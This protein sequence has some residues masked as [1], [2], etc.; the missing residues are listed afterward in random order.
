[1]DHDPVTART[2][3]KGPEELSRKLRLLPLVAMVCGF[4]LSLSASG[5]EYQTGVS[6]TMLKKSSVTGNGRK[7]VYPVTDNA[8]VTAMVVELA[9]GAE[10]GWH[11]HPIP[12]YGY[13]L[14]GTIDVELEGGQVIVY[15]SGDAIIEAVDTLHNGRN[16]GSERVRLVVFYTGVAGKPNV[17]RPVPSSPGSRLPPR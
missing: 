7:I 5:D 3:E 16:R 13:V 11:S 6:A 10:T 15:R 2:K 1:M 8:E 14:T 12:V 17:V 9:P 4:F